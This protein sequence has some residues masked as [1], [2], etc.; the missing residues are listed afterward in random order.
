LADVSRAVFSAAS[1]ALPAVKQSMVSHVNFVLDTRGFFAHL[2]LTVPT[3]VVVPD[4]VQ[5]T[6]FETLGAALAGT[7]TMTPPATISAT[8]K[9]AI[10]RSMKEPFVVI[11]AIVSIYCLRK[12]ENTPRISR[13]DR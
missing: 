4:F 10:L 5:A 8:D 6:P 13:Y 11:E 1:V 2:Y 7:A 3:L 12:T 9:D